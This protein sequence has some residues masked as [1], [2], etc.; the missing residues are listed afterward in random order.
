LRKNNDKQANFR[1]VSIARSLTALLVGKA[2]LVASGTPLFRPEVAL[3]PISWAAVRTTD[4]LAT[5]AVDSALLLISALEPTIGAWA[6]LDHDRARG[7][8]AEAAMHGGSLSGLVAGVKDIF[9]TAD[10]PSEYGSPIYA[11]HR[12]RADASAVALLREG[13]AVCIGKTVTSEF[14]FA[15]PGPTANPHRTTHTPGGSSMG[16]AA[17]VAAGMVDFAIG[18]Q[19]AGSIIKPASFCGVYGF[20]PTFGS[21]SI[22]GAKT[23]APSLDTVG[24]FARDP[25]LLDQV[26]MELTGQP[27]AAV[28]GNG[29]T[30]GLLR[31]E[32]WN[33]CAEDS[34]RAVVAAADIA[35]ALGAKVVNLDMP[36]PLVGLADKQPVLMAYEASRSLAWEH[37]VKRD[38]LSSELREMLDRGR[39]TNPAEINAVRA[40]KSA[41]LA[42]CGEL[43]ARCSVILTPAVIGEAPQGRGQSGDSRFARLWSLLGLPAVCIPAATGST[44]MPV[45]VQLVAATGN[46]AHLL[47]VAAWL[48]GGKPVPLAGAHVPQG[49]LA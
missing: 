45:G 18:T 6:Y 11:G 41:A 37:R 33:E 43:F 14:A 49:V 24:W 40:R 21:V 2:C 47:A 22:A 5:D 4:R 48:T 9:D 46:D 44:G 30:V 29:P 38:E 39:R 20:K 15:H 34:M 19:T 27:E 36:G 35:Q 31:T 10:Q 28:L 7:E 12:P 17:A 8:A 42:S 13:G 32:Q 25:F 26:R 23:F 16:S 3:R 1:Y